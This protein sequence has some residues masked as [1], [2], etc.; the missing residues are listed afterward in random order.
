MPMKNFPDVGR[1]CGNWELLSQ[2]E[3]GRREMRHQSPAAIP[4]ITSKHPRKSMY[5]PR[6]PPFDDLPTP[7]MSVVRCG[8]GQRYMCLPC[9]VTKTGEA[10]AEF[11]RSQVR[12]AQLLLGVSKVAIISHQTTL[13][14]PV[15]AHPGQ[16]QGTSCLFQHG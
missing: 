8:H 3:V 2:E 16:L 4:E 6:K 14:S 13:G 10:I 7:E 11:R 9:S 15:F 5:F 12:G 1:S